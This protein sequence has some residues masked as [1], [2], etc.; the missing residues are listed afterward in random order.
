MNF[1]NGERFLQ[2][3]WIMMLLFSAGNSLKKVF[4]KVQW[5]SL[6]RQG[7]P[8][9]MILRSLDY[10]PDKND[11]RMSYNN[12]GAKASL[13]SLTMDSTN[14]SYDFDMYYNY[15]HQY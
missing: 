2:D 8:M 5:I 14:F 13:S 1:E 7:M 15:F 9:V 10:S 4:L 3:I 12:I 11:I 6:R